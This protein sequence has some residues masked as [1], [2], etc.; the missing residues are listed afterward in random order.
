MNQNLEKT[1]IVIFGTMHLE[2][3]EFPAYGKRLCEIIEEINPDIICS[4]LSPEQ[5]DGTQSCNSKPEQRDVIMPTAKRLGIPIV[6]IQPSTEKASEWEKRFKAAD[7]KL[8][9]QVPSRHY[10]EYG[11]QLAGREAE[12]W[13]GLM[14]NADCIENVQLNEYHLFSEAR[15]RVESQLLPEREK[16]LDEWNENFL[17]KIEETFKSNRGRRILVMAGLWHKYWL[18]N[19]LSVRADVSVHNL[20]SYRR[21]IKAES[22]G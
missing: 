11:E 8:R 6:P 14:K 2:P 13:S 20:Q 16:L 7:G 1:I 3:E 4:E 18:W 22:R 21:A 19:W 17:R 9:S 12:L 5:L 15:D 10:I